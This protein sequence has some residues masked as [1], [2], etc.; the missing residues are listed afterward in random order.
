MIRGNHS[1]NEKTLTKEIE[2][3]RE[4]RK[5]VQTIHPILDL[6]LLPLT[7]LLS[8]DLSIHHLRMFAPPMRPTSAASNHHQQAYPQHPQHA[9]LTR[10]RSQSWDQNQGLPPPPSQID[11]YDLSNAL[12]NNNHNHRH[13]QYSD[14][15]QSLLSDR[16][17]RQLPMNSVSKHPKLKLD[18]ILTSNTFEA[19][20]NI[21]GRLEITSA[22]S[23]RLRLGEIAVELEGVEGEWEERERE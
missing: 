9:Q 3:T 12:L 19:G 17:T 5:K 13:P 23:Q 22:T 7:L 18:V 14:L 20:G 4:R 15:D 6:L 21:D 11:N 1:S 16:D 10:R 8:P 2:R